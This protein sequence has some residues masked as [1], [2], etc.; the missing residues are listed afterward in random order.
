MRFR[1]YKIKRF[2]AHL[3]LFADDIEVYDLETAN[4]ARDPTIF[5]N[6]VKDGKLFVL[7]FKRLKFAPA[8]LILKDISHHKDEILNLWMDCINLPQR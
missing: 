3:R 2:V 6:G 4:M 1:D 7:E 5:I 8:E